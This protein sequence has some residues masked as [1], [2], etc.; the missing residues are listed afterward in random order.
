VWAFILQ[1]FQGR[2][3]TRVIAAWQV[4]HPEEALLLGLV[5]VPC[6]EDVISSVLPGVQG[7]CNVPAE[8][9]A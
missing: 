9:M 6:H 7:D 8:K 3:I 2:L 4:V 5:T 1:E